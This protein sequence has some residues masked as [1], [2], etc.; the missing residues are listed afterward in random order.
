M[1][2]L[3]RA[4]VVY[5]GEN[6]ANQEDHLAQLQIIQ[7]LHRQNPNL[8][9]AMEMFQRPFQVYLDR[10]LGNDLMEMRLRELTQYRRRWGYPWEYYAPILRFAKANRLPVLAIDTLAEISNQVAR[11]GLESLSPFEQQYI[12]PFSDIRT[13][14]L[15]YRQF[16]SQIYDRTPSNRRQTNNFDRYFQAQVVRNETMA[17]AIAK[18]LKANPD[19][20]IVVITGQSPIVYRY[21][22][23][24]CVARRLGGA[25][26]IQSTVLINPPPDLQITSDRP[27]SDFIW[28]T[29]EVAN[30][31]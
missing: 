31:G 8:A 23:P 13:D 22:I 18:F 1:Q 21:G 24:S 16:L 7:Q 10:Y 17:D 25:N 12:P 2:Q 14:N 9:I 3:A 11:R 20:Q 15:E 4:N 30:R 27:I 5:L 28:I 19:F 6:H 26:L 29:R